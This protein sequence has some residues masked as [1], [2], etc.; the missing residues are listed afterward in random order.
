[1][2]TGVVVGDVEHPVAIYEVV[3]G[4]NLLLARRARIEH[5]LWLLWHHR[6]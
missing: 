6:K 5:L 1:M 2:E 4:L 3:A